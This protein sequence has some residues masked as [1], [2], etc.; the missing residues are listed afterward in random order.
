LQCQRSGLFISFYKGDWDTEDSELM[1]QGEIDAN[2]SCPKKEDEGTELNES[3]FPD[4]F[5]EESDEDC[6]EWE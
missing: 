1:A 4:R 5:I 2:S 6:S 3:M